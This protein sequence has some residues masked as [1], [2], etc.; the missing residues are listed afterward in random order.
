[1][2]VGLGKNVF[3]SCLASR[4]SIGRFSIV[5]DFQWRSIFDTSGFPSL[6][7]KPW[8]I[9]LRNIRSLK[10]FLENI[11]PPCRNRM[12]SLFAFLKNHKSIII[13]KCITWLAFSS[14]HMRLTLISDYICRCLNCLFY[15]YM[16]MRFIKLC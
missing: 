1:M 10:P 5:T 15:F 9:I 13:N 14:T 12:V 8:P 16:V 7:L 6:L 3:I 2:F 4:R 11:Y